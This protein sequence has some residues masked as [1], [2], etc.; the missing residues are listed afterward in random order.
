MGRMGNWRGRTGR[1]EDEEEELGEDL[2]RGARG[3]ARG[4]GMREDGGGGGGERKE[5]KI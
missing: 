3:G 5:Y 4:G 1:G 2:D